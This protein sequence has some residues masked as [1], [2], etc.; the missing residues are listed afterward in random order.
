[1]L[2]GEVLYRFMGKLLF[3]DNFIS[4]FSSRL[5]FLMERRS[6]VIDGRENFKFVEFNRFIEHLSY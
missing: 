5:K 4:R 6:Y 2:F 3:F 1:M